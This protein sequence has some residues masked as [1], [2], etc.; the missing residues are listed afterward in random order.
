MVIRHGFDSL[1]T[2]A[3][4]AQSN[5]LLKNSRAAHG[6]QPTSRGEA[7]PLTKARIAPYSNHCV[8]PLKGAIRMLRCRN[9]SQDAQCVC[10]A[11]A[12]Y[13]MFVCLDRASGDARRRKPAEAA[14]N[15]I[16]ALTLTGASEVT[17]VSGQDEPRGRQLLERVRAFRSNA[18]S[19]SCR[20]FRCAS[21]Y[22]PRCGRCAPGGIR[23]CG[24]RCACPR[25][26]VDRRRRRDGATGARFP[27]P[28]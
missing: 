24:R 10:R 13:S 15:Q 4:S 3:T 19:T 27:P 12:S 17:A 9:L 8:S 5:V 25:P 2:T 16:G 23:A 7:E 11:P 1:K 20:R 22:T 21:R 28:D 14:R 6:L 18:R 26:I